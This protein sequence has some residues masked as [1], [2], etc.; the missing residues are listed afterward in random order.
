V[1]AAKAEAAAEALKEH[2]R[3]LYV[4][5]T[6]AKDFLYVCGF[7]NKKGVR[8][9]SWYELAQRAAQSLGKA[10]AHGEDTLRVIGDAEM[11]TALPAPSPEPPRIAL[12][13][14]VAAEPA[15]E[16]ITP[17]LIRPSDAAGLEEPG[18]FSP[19]GPK[20]A[21]RFRRGQLVH[22]LLARLPEI[23]PESRRDVALAYLAA[24]DV[25]PEEADALAEETLAVISDPRFAAAF[26]PTARAEVAIVADLPELGLGARASGRIDRLAVS[27]DE[28][29]AIDFKT[30]RPP[31]E[32]V[33]DVPV[34]YR[35]QMALYRAALAKV[36]PGR[37]I[38]CALI[39]TEGP[40]LM[41]LDDALLDAE[42]AHIRTRLDPGGYGS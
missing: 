24:R 40:R 22:T 1:K 39:W 29:L 6:R 33:E 27:A 8:E 17:R 16:H 20:A 36:F 23:E 7:E 14:W 13:Q 10:V 32:R 15:P 41:A 26:T 12:P 30:N 5:L 11:E 21:A 3:L 28:V 9:G 42:T 18:V 4:A 38:A 2:R 35:A 19:A 25:L 31:P 37:R 34:L